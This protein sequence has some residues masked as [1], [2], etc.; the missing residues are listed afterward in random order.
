MDEL[1]LYLSLLTIYENN[2]RMLHWKLA[3]KGFHTAH[4]RFGKYYEELGQYMDET[5]EQIISL[6][7]SPV[8]MAEAIGIVRESDIDAF[9]IESN[10]DYDG[11]SANSAAR[12]M[13]DQL[14]AAADIDDL[15]DDVEDVF[16]GH[17]RYYRLEGMYKLGRAGVKS[18]PMEHHPEP[19]PIPEEEEEDDD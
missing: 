12:K 17:R 4:E 19:E 6:G 18:G 8:N 3:G 9:L 16:V 10:R 2:M 15:P 5:A 11:M 14:Y 13:F 1:R 7:G